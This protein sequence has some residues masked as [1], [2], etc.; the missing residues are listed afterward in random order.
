MPTEDELAQQTPALKKQ[1]KGST[2]KL[3]SIGRRRPRRPRNG[4]LPLFDREQV[5]SALRGYDRRPFLDLLA[6]WMECAPDPEALIDFADAHP[7]R[8]ASALASIGKLGGFTEKK[9]I[10]V[11][12]NINVRTMSDSQ[13]EDRLAELK[14]QLIEGEAIDVT[15]EAEGD[16]GRGEAEIASE[17]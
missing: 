6:V 1:P 16:S 8:W 15:D 5:V 17:R 10:E 4:D 13:L 14:Q 9:E 3:D 7:D 2:G 12:I 11:D